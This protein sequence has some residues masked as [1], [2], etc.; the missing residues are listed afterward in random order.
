M[1]GFSGLVAQ[2][3][4]QQRASGAAIGEVAFLIAENSV[5]ASCLAVGVVTENMGLLPR[6]RDT[7]GGQVGKEVA[8]R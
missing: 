2:Q 3:A 5:E 1:S 7:T 6:N 4:L 8:M